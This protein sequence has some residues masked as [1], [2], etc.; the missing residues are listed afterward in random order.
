M[1]HSDH[2]AVIYYNKATMT[3]AQRLRL[4]TA[5]LLAVASVTFLVFAIRFS[6]WNN[7]GLAVVSF[8]CGFYAFDTYTFWHQ[9]LKIGTPTR[10]QSA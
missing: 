9:V 1:D 7:L 2:Q 10:K 3:W 5:A 4:A 6:D 8:C